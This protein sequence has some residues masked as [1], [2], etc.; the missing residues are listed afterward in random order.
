[1]LGHYI[2]TRW[3]AAAQDE[4]TAEREKEHR[5]QS[6]LAAEEHRQGH[7]RQKKHQGVNHAVGQM[8]KGLKFGKTAYVG[9]QDAGQELFG[10]LD[11]PLGPSKLLALEGIDV[12]WDFG[13][14]HQ[15]DQVAAAPAGKLNPVG[16][17][18]VLGQGV[19][20]PV[21]GLRHGRL[22]GIPGR[23]V[24]IHKK[25][26]KVTGRLFD[27]E[28]TVYADRLQPGDKAFLAVQMSPAALHKSK[29]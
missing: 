14:R 20:L 29:L 24:E 15:V 1:M 17:V 16:Q 10:G 25:A 8:H 7:H 11:R 5:R 22:S 26:I 4:Q 3:A 21:A 13:E 9:L 12:A 2:K 18:H 28:V 23:T 6:W 27:H 19:V